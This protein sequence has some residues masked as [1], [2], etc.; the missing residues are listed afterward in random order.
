MIFKQYIHDVHSQ[1]IHVV[2]SHHSA[3]M[4]Q[5]GIC[6]YEEEEDDWNYVPDQQILLSCALY[7]YNYNLVQY[8]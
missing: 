6:N 2:Y 3:T 5:S 8:Y 1:H 7:T 4:P